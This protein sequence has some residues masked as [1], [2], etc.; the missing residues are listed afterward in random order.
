MEPSVHLDESPSIKPPMIS[1]FN[2]RICFDGETDEH[3]LIS[4][5]KCTGSM[6]YVH[7]DCLKIWLLS[8]DKDLSLAECDICKYNLKMKISLA[9]KC[10]CK[11]FWNECL[12]MFIF[13]I[14]LVLM[15]SILLVI[16]LFLIQGIQNGTSSTGEQTYLILL[17]IACTIIIIIILVVFSKSIKRGCCSAE[18]IG[19]HIESIAHEDTV[20]FT[21]EHH[22]NNNTMVNDDLQVM[23]MPKF[24]KFG[25]RNV[26]R[27]EIAT[28]R[29]VPIMRSGE[30]IG[31]RQRV[32]ESRSLGASQSSGF[33]QISHLDL[34]FNGGAR[35]APGK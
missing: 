35:V 15:T 27:P 16:M 8:R 22:V 2:C 4:P 3:K 30:L 24:S 23:V 31:Y 18:M 25:G 33:S 17:M 14:L 20:E 26:V 1:D 7:E 6:R 13:P 19:W 28:P 12:G 10:T 11:N 9:T 5:C 29:L 34:S 32:N 21:I